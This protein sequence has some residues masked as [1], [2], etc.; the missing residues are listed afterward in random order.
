M[1]TQYADRLYTTEEASE[2]KPGINGIKKDPDPRDPDPGGGVPVPPTP[3][4][5][6]EFQIQ[7][8][9]PKGAVTSDS[10]SGLQDQ[11][12]AKLSGCI[13]E[14]RASV[15]ADPDSGMDVVRVGGWT[16][17]STWNPALATARINAV[18]NIQILPF[19]NPIGISFAKNV[20]GSLAYREAIKA[21]PDLWGTQVDL[22]PSNIVDVV[23][24]V[25]VTD[26][27]LA[28]IT[29]RDTVSYTASTPAIVTTQ[30]Q[31]L[32]P[33]WV[34]NTSIPPGITKGLAGQLMEQFASIPLTDRGLQLVLSYRHFTITPAALSFEMF[35]VFQGL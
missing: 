22:R 34:P 12:L 11:L 18:Q 33:W 20:L 6:P 23:L 25:R 27:L 31:F 29:L 35:Y 21:K 10:L 4:V 17:V 13:F 24:Q 5:T 26:N 30:R 1:N 14:V 7:A 2:A 19:G 28:N 15:S 16:T 3:V 32:K 9:V 8:Q